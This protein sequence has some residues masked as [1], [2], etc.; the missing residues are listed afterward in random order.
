M[1]LRTMPEDRKL[2]LLAAAVL[3]IM[4]VGVALMAPRQE[5]EIKFPSTY[6]ADSEGGKAAYLLL[7][8][9]GYK[10][11]RWLHKP[12]DLPQG[13]GNVLILAQPFRPATHEDRLAVQRFIARGGRIV[14]VGLFATMLLPDE[15]AGFGAAPK[16]CPT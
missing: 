10:V 6:S 14:A 12:E 7:S 5:E 8:E 16:G 11:E 13:R 15:A 4:L 1:P 3:V 9:S 2:L